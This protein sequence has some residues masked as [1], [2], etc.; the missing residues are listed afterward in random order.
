LQEGQE[1]DLSDLSEDDESEAEDG[2]ASEV[3]ASPKQRAKGK[4]SR[5]APAGKKQPLKRKAPAK[6]S[7]VVVLDAGQGDKGTDG[8]KTDNG[9]FSEY[10]GR[11]VNGRTM[12]MVA[13]AML[14]SDI[15]LQSFVEDWVETYLDTGGDEDAENQIVSELVIFFIRVSTA[16]L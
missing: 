15:A 14:Q 13:D 6:T 16:L 2:S 9:L 10:I 12:L 8:I 11:A 3:E 4:G 5:K 1:S 7:D